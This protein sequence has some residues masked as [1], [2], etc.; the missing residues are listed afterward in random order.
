MEYFKN[1]QF[2]R[3]ADIP[4]H[5]VFYPCRTFDDYYAIQY[6]HSGHFSLQINDGPKQASDAPCAFLTYPGARFA[7]GGA[8]GSSY[9]HLYVCFRGPLAEAWRVGDLLRCLG[10]DALIPILHP[11]DFFTKFERMIAL[12]NGP[13]RNRSH[14]RAVLLLADLLLQMAEEE[15][16]RH[17]YHNPFAHQMN[18]LAKEISHAPERP[19][20]F[21]Q[22]ARRMNISYPYFRRVFEELF[23]EPPHHFLLQCRLQ[24][25]EA[26]LADNTLRIGEVAV[27]CGFQDEFYFS[28][29][30]KKYHGAS[31]LRYRKEHLPTA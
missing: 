1:L 8:E 5:L 26:M 3:A 27:Q 29:L 9:H 19:W 16:F 25:A 7:Y 17:V 11:T 14:A 23:L 4:A 22:E 6:C 28:R 13:D 2:I 10:K 30:F 15:R 18:L 24:K 20:D 21:G 12:L 31:P